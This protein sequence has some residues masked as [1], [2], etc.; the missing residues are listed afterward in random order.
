MSRLFAAFA[1]ASCVFSTTAASFDWPQWRGPERD[2]KSRETGLLQSWPEGGPRQLWKAT[3]LGGGYAAPS[4]ANGRI[5]GA[6]YRGSDEFVWALGENDGK[7]IWSVKTAGAERNIGYPEG[8]RATPTIDGDS[9]YTLSAGGVFVC[10]GT[11]DGQQRWSKD[12]KNDFGGRMMS[13]W[14]FSES[15]LVDGEKVVCTPG[16]TKGTVVALNKKTGAV[17]WQTKDFTDRAAYASLIVAEIGGVRQYIQLT[18]RRVVG[19]AANDGKVLWDASR[20]GRTAVIPTP[21][22][23]DDQVFVT[24]GYGVGCNLFKISHDNGVFKATEVYANHDIENHHGG[25]V[26]VGDYLYGHSDS[27]GWVCMEF[28]TGKVMWTNKGVGKGSVSFADGMLYTRSEGR[29]GTVALVEATPTAYKENGRFDQPERSSKNSWP[30]PVIANGKLLL[31]DQSILFC[32][33]IKKN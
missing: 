22:Y 18:D 16:G 3:G 13:G 5:F 19:I 2:G 4:V 21:I 17:I 23:H 7:E 15:P 31:R 28:K 20:P 26:L 29:A 14:G 11:A 12:F 25:V 24:S 27:R 6:G 10:L 9:L 30:H 1:A 32:Y 33:D 8:P